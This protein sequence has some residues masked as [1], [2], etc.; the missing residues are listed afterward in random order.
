[1]KHDKSIWT[2]QAKSL[3]KDLHAELS[4]NNYTWHKFRGNKY[5]RSAELMISAISLL[6]NNG[7]EAEI[8]ILLKQAIS[9]IRDDIKDNGCS[10]H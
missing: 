8:E 6:I 10:H 2:E 9:W 1:M 7:D 3:A 4:I 5:R